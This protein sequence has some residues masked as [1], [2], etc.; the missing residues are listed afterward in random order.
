MINL[1]VEFE[2]SISTH[3]KDM[4]G[5]A[6]YKLGAVWVTWGSLEVRNIKEDAKRKNMD[7]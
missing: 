7:N 4:E 5:D 6:K 1:A 2:F 3:Y